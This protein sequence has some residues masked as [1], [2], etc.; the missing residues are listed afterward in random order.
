MISAPFIIG[1][2]FIANL[3]EDGGPAYVNEHAKYYKSQASVF[4]T[5]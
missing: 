2:E 4:S 1:G 5:I 3:G